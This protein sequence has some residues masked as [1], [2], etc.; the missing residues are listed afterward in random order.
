VAA[1]RTAEILSTIAAAGRDDGGLPH[2]L[3]TACGRALPVSGVGMVLMSH[4]GPAGTVAVTDGSAAKLEDLQFTLGEGPCVDASRSG[5]PVLQP[6]LAATGPA[7]WPGFAS[8]AL[9]AGIEAIFA[10]PLRM[11]A[12]RLGVL[13]L[14]RDRAGAL[15]EPELAEALAFADA[16]TML[17]L[18]L[19]SLD[20]DGR[21]P[22]GTI[23]VV[24]DHAEVHQATGMVSVQ[25]AV[26]LGQAIGLLQARAF[27]TSRP[28]TAVARD[29]LTGR[30]RFSNDDRGRIHEQ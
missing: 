12:I 1:A 8:A 7:R 5:R 17:L 28:I 15:S 10:F 27:A 23:P 14:Y 13:D 29:V 16:A 4:D 11:G 9:D 25:A 6:D 19:Q 3:V 22:L 24:E 30:V 20:P 21:G 26:P 18:Q 2:R